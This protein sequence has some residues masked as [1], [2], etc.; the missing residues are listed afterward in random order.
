[1][2][3]GLGDSTTISIP[4]TQRADLSV[5]TPV[6]TQSLCS[7]MLMG[8]PNTYT[9]RAQ[10]PTNVATEQHPSPKPGR[11]GL[12]TTACNAGFCHHGCNIQNG[13]HGPWN[14]TSTRK[15]RCA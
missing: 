11:Y 7:A 2:C 1:M 8:P 5:A 3:D 15:A 4:Q 6:Y 14:T 9:E 10:P 12:R 13:V